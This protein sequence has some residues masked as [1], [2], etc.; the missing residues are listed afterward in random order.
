MRRSREFV[1][2]AGGRRGVQPCPSSLGSVLPCRVV[3]F[4]AAL[5]GFAGVALNETKNNFL[6]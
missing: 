5:F 6:I 1:A 3:F 2:A 4:E